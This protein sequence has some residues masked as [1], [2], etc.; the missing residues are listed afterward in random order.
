MS[1]NKGVSPKTDQGSWKAAV[2]IPLIVLVG[3]IGYAWIFHALR[4]S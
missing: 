4:G 1:E 2:I 3:I